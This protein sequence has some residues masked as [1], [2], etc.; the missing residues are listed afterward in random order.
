MKY[1]GYDV[2]TLGCYIP[3]HQTKKTDFDFECKLKMVKVRFLSVLTASNQQKKTSLPIL[4]QLIELSEQ[5]ELYSCV[6]KNLFSALAL[7]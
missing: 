6:K 5:R 3:I 1:K 4:S 7:T 2:H